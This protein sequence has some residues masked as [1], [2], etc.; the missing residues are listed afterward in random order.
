[1]IRQIEADNTA[2]FFSFYSENPQKALANIAG[3]VY[4]FSGGLIPVRPAA[5][6]FFHIKKSASLFYFVLYFPLF[7]LVS[8]NYHILASQLDR[9]KGRCN[10]TAGKRANVLVPGELT[11]VHRYSQFRKANENHFYGSLDSSGCKAAGFH[12]KQ[13]YP[14]SPNFTTANSTKEII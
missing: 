8:G 14:I 7:A 1:M 6:S 2:Q 3:P 9:L 5:S 11:I 4:I 12:C 10:R 13:F